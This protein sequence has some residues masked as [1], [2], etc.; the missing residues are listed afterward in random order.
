MF[1][2]LELPFLTN[3]KVA[4]AAFGNAWVIFQVPAFRPL[5]NVG[6]RMTLLQGGRTVL[7]R[8][9]E[10]VYNSILWQGANGWCLPFNSSGESSISRQTQN[11]N[12][13][14]DVNHLEFARVFLEEKRYLYMCEINTNLSLFFLILLTTTWL[15]LGNSTTWQCLL[16][17]KEVSFFTT[18]LTCIMV[19]GLLGQQSIQEAVADAESQKS[20]FSD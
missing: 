14:C 8:K 6:H 19:Q 9:W 1:S 4:E 12:V 2:L 20:L 11:M 3:L 18:K 10:S 13:G 16:A 7:R 17:L 5:E 15:Q